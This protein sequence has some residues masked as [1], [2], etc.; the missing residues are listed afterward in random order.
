[1]NNQHVRV[2]AQ[3]HPLLSVSKRVPSGLC[4]LPGANIL[5][6]K[7][8]PMSAWFGIDTEYLL[9]GSNWLKSQFSSG[10]LMSGDDLTPGWAEWVYNTGKGGFTRWC[11]CLA[12]PLATATGC[13]PQ[14]PPA[15]KTGRGPCCR[16]L[17]LIYMN[18]SLCNRPARW[19]F[20]GDTSV[21]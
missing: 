8:A 17:S 6:F 15:S 2:C 18:P 7:S 19:C 1:M 12:P 20:T 10:Y 14:S 4:E 11:C 21:S 5:V 13:S 9:L 3:P 16:G